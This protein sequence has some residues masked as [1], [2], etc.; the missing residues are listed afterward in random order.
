M[1]TQRLNDKWSIQLKDFLYL[2]PGGC[3]FFLGLAELILGCLLLLVEE[4]HELL[5]E[6][7]FEVCCQTIDFLV[8]SGFEIGDLF[9]SVEDLRLELFYF[10][11]VVVEVVIDDLASFLFINIVLAWR[12]LI[13]EA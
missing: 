12:L 7:V 11:Q 4:F 2:L 5:S 10:C 9:E 3:S 13:E 6:L 1:E 8:M